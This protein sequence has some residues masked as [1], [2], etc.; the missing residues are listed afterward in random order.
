M[1]GFCGG[2]VN[3]TSQAM[4]WM[5]PGRPSGKKSARPLRKISS[6]PPVGTVVTQRP[7]VNTVV[8]PAPPK[9]V[10]AG[11]S[12]YV[13]PFNVTWLVELIVTPP[14]GTLPTL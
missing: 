5:P 14:A 13:T 6:L 2:A 7:S 1:A 10:R 11:G 8:G 4:S 9:I 12:V 3:E